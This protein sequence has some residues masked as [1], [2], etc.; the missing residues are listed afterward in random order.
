M[1]SHHSHLLSKWTLRFKDPQVEVAFTKSQLGVLVRNVRFSVLALL[2]LMLASICT[3][4][5]FGIP[6]HENLPEDHLVP[7]ALRD[8]SIW[9]TIF[10]CLLLLLVSPLFLQS[11]CRK[12]R[13]GD[14]KWCLELPLVA[15]KEY[16]LQRNDGASLREATQSELA[17]YSPSPSAQ[18]MLRL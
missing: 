13:C 3:S 16:A 7:R 18:Q 17:R 11:Q 5:H 10:W 9:F 4:P 14:W 6:S 1:E 12:S 15:S 8:G 2:V